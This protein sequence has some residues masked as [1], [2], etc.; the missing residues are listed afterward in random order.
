MRTLLA[1]SDTRAL[2]ACLSNSLRSSSRRRRSV[3]ALMPLMRSNIF[4][5]AFWILA[6][7]GQVEEN[8]M[9]EN[10]YKNTHAEYS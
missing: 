3:A 9:K 4:A 5:F 10:Q 8:A 6:G 7:A 1:F 2:K